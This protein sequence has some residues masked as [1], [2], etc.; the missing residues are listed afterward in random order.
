M[1]PYTNLETFLQNRCNVLQSTTPSDV[2]K[3]TSSNRQRVMRTYF[4]NQKP[5]RGLKSCVYCKDNQLI[6]K[7]DS[8]KAETQTERNEFAR[9]NNL[10]FNWLSPNH[11][12]STCKAN[13]NCAIC[14]RKRNTLLHKELMPIPND[15]K[16]KTVS[17]H[18]TNL[19]QK[20]I[21]LPTAQV[22]IEASNESLIKC[23]TLLNS[24]SQVNY[25][26]RSFAK[27]NSFKLESIQQKIIG[28]ANQESCARQITEIT[29]R[30]ATTNYSANILCLVLPEI[31]GAI[32]TVM[33]NQQ[34][35][36]IPTGIQ[37]SD[38]LWN[39]PAAIDLLL[40]AEV[41]VHPMKA[42]TIKLGSGMP[43]LSSRNRSVQTNCLM[44]GFRG[45][46]IH[47]TYV[48]LSWPP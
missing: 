38:P 22:D 17:A 16:R 7:C 11:R 42:G 47:E 27:R 46:T 39:K 9:N 21:V 31:T 25:V 15:T 29:I 44:V 30:S 3:E 13:I 26:T 41:C 4:T 43:S 8:F 19:S 40:G 36:S 10:C 28:I 18:S 14:K 12:T 35:I 23:R 24:G 6:Y 33:L 45:L 5:S 2:V 34:L 32:P 20:E 48:C 1:P 37:L